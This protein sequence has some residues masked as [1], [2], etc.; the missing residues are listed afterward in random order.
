MNC[1]QCLRQVGPVGAGTLAWMLRK[2]IEA[3]YEELVMAESIGLVHIRTGHGKEPRLWVFGDREINYDRTTNRAVQGSREKDPGRA[4]E[5]KEA[6]QR[7][8]AVGAE[9]G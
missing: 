3:V 6:E 4:H 1:V 7:S 2:P 9:V 8:P 5:R